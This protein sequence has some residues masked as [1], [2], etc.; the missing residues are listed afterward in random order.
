[1]AGARQILL[2]NSWD[3][4]PQSLWNRPQKT[5]NRRP[6]SLPVLRLSG[7]LFPSAGTD[8][9]KLRFAILVRRPPFGSYPSLLLHPQKGGVQSTLVELQEFLADLFDPARDPVAV[10]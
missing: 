2:A 9:V 1:P 8:R 3:V 6:H 7:E 5:I 4:V 10:Q